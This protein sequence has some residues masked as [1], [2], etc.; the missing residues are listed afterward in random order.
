M[1][2]LP[3]DQIPHILTAITN[4]FKS[5]PFVIFWSLRRSVQWL[6]NVLLRCILVGEIKHCRVIGRSDIL[7]KKINN[8]QYFKFHLFCR[9]LS[10]IDYRH[11]SK[12]RFECII[13]SYGH[14][15]GQNKCYGYFWENN[16]FSCRIKSRNFLKRSYIEHGK[17][18]IDEHLAKMQAHKSKNDCSSKHNFLIMCS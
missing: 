13:V 16:H 9:V 3:L 5:R 8:R 14:G 10:K 4:R 18:K 2:K 17:F 7:D 6:C 1:I 12:L 11:L 15:M